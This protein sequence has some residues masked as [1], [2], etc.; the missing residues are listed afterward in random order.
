MTIVKDIA[1]RLELLHTKLRKQDRVSVITMTAYQRF[2]GTTLTQVVYL[3]GYSVIH[4]SDINTL[5]RIFVYTVVLHLSGLIGTESHP[6][7]QKTRIIGFIFD[8]TLHWQFEWKR[9]LYK[10]PF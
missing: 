6:D 7:T 9:N 10:R 5:N 3:S 8:N 4:S 2:S 1:R